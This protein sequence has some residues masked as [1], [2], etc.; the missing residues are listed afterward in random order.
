MF[1]QQFILGLNAALPSDSKVVLLEHSKL[2][3]PISNFTILLLLVLSSLK[4]VLLRIPVTISRLG[5]RQFI[6]HFN[7]IRFYLYSYLNPI[8]L[9]SLLPPQESI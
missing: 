1:N 8:L 3:F 4:D 6:R 7:F 5:L 9:A 2:E